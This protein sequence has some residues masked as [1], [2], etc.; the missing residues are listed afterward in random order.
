[1]VKSLLWFFLFSVVLGFGWGEVAHAQSSGAKQKN[2]AFYIVAH[3]D[4]WQLFMGSHAYDDIQ[5]PKTKVIIIC[6]TAGQ[7]N[8]PGDAYWQSREV[9]CRA[10]I[11]AAADLSTQM[12]PDSLFGEETVNTHLVHTFRHKNVVAYFLRLPDGGF[13]GKGF[14]RGNFQSVRQFKNGKGGPLTSI[15][16][17]ASYATWE[18]LTETV[19]RIVQ[20][21]SA[22]TKCTWVHT[23]DPNETYNPDDH[24]DHRMAGVIARI[25]TA[26]Q[27]CRQLLY[28]EYA[29][30]KKPEN[31]SADEKAH[32]SLLF[33]AYCKGQVRA[34]Q[35]TEWNEAHLKWLGRQYFRM[36]HN[37]DP[38]T[39]KPEV[40]A[41]VADSTALTSANISLNANYP[42]PF[43]LSSTVGYTLPKA[44]FVTLQIF[45][46]QGL[47]LK[48]MVQAT[49]SVGYHEVW[50][51]AD[52]FPAAGQYICRLQVGQ[53]H[54]YRRIEVAR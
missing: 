2:A 26:D 21:E 13:N 48:T 9:G 22:G 32:Q 54:R 44:A 39:K 53:E 3:Q 16:K 8:E 7:A 29:S 10:S 36:R 28:V 15:D 30:S 49:Q 45:S 31:L 34:G 23:P 12:G 33:A 6:L 40:V 19:H 18:D 27:D 41:Y 4:D 17:T 42:N 14:A 5:R 52:Q 20:R 47:L 46:M 50:L 38:T 51:N 11:Q 35:V 25:A 24:P 37:A 1:M 43:S